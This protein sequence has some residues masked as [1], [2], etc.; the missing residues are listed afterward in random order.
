MHFTIVSYTFPPSTEIGGRRWAKFSKHLVQ[1]GHEVTVICANNVINQEFYEKEFPGIDVKVLPKCYPDWLSGVTKSLREKLLYLIYTRIVSHLT[2]QNLFDRGYAWKKT[3]LTELE[4]VHHKKPIDVMVVTGA[5]FSL[6]Y[7]GSLF[8]M[9][10][11]EIQY[12]VDF[13]DPWTWGS[14]YGIPTLSS[15]KKKYQDL[16]EYK[17]MEVCDMVCYPIENM[18]V[19]LKE[20]Y[21]AF[22]SKLYLLPHAYDPDKFPSFSKEEKREGFIYGGTLYDGIEK[23]IKELAEIV[24]ANPNSGFKWDIY[25]GTNYPLINSDFANGSIQKHSFITEEQLFQKITK[26]A[27]YLV[28]FPNTD[29]DLISTKF[30]EIIYTQTPIVYIGDEGDVGKFIRDNR[31]GVHILPENM[32]RD[33]PKYLS[34]NVPFEKDYFDVTQ[35]TF[36]SVTEKFL[37]ALKDF[38]HAKNSEHILLI[39]YTFPP[40]PGIGGRRWAK[41]AKYLSRLGYTVHVIHAKNPFNEKSLWL[42]DVENNEHIKT[43]Q[44]NI[45]YPNILLTIPKSFFQK[46]KYKCSLFVVNLFSKGTPY[47]RGIFWRKNMLKKSEEL[48]R[49]YNIK[50]VVSNCAPFSSAYYA[51]ELKK[52]FNDLN[53][54]VDFRDPWTWGK[55]YGFSIL[56]K[57]RFLFEKEK[58]NAVIENSNFIFVP[59]IEMKNHLNST[60]PKFSNNVILLPHGFDKDEIT[61]KPKKHSEVIKLIFYGSLYYNLEE[62]F[63]EIAGCLS[64]FNDKIFLDLYSST[65]AYN[66]LFDSVNLLNKTVNYYNPL[67]PKQLF[68][69]MDGYDFVL[70]VQ[71]DYAK[72]FITTKIYEIINSGTPIILISSE[73]K[74]SDFIIQNN[75]GLWFT[76]EN[77]RKNFK[78]VFEAKSN[79]FN[80]NQFKI[81]EF[82]Y[83]SITPKL[84]SYFK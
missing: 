4:N 6:L 9:R 58:E 64:D 29:K 46:I 30:F 5:P 34:G 69:K 49:T 12:V 73:G 79:S 84:T 21:P 50:N 16:S 52:Q 47:D 37:L 17:T 72:D 81:E 28:F 7:Y 26:S 66:Q 42:D 48:I 74:L 54:M 2:K 70:I 83:T 24:M 45:R 67:L 78:T 27:A 20:K 51:L 80:L 1:S 3:M 10:Y 62:V 59:S 65:T 39:S 53:L 56:E 36:S 11:R 77:L 63:S 25:S 76:L 18:G 57:N 44:L 35:Y 23:Y 19:V 61:L 15:I 8:K 55:G 40:Y 43:Y 22:S 14:Y 33:L 75:L 32:K 60:Y 13:R 38:K 68:N 41:F 82:S 31:L 71:P